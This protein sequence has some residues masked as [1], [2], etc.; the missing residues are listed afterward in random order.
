MAPLVSILLPA[1]QA[2]AT[3]SAALRSIQRQTLE[4][5]ECVVVDDGSRDETAEIAARIA[6]ADSR[7]VLL[8]VGH[9]G[10]VGALTQGLAV[11]RGRYVARMDADDL[12]H[13]QRLELQVSCLERRPELGAVGAHVWMFPRV[14]LS[15][16][17]RAHEAWL[18]SLDEPAS[19]ARDAF[20]ECPIVH[21]TLT[22]RRELL[23]AHGYRDA[24]WPQD[25]D[26]VL[27]LLAQGVELAVLPRRL[28]GWRDGPGRITRTADYTRRERIVAC[29]AH[30]LAESFLGGTESYVL[31]GYGDTG[32]SLSRALSAHGKH[33]HTIVE[34]HPRRIGQRIAGAPVVHPSALA[35]S[36]CPK[37][38]IS[39]SGLPG[40]SEARARAVA[41]GLREGADFVVAA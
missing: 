30:H 6:R 18:N 1:Y 34:L 41:L 20:V 19:I 16:G 33:P 8:S 35:T 22:I 9:Q 38:V 11:C 26:L 29:K 5:F 2:A 40:R 28:L 3:L 32:R 13:K 14:S 15:D 4:D 23:E 37:V 25:Y 27:R 31:W 21:P 39:V 36:E 24:G 10:I 12:S 17:L 7:F